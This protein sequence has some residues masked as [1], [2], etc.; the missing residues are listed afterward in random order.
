MS[1]PIVISKYFS[2]S[3]LPKIIPTVKKQQ[4]QDE[5]PT[6]ELSQHTDTDLNEQL[7]EWNVNTQEESSQKEEAS[8][9]SFLSTLSKK[10]ID[11]DAKDVEETEKNLGWYTESKTELDNDNELDQ[12]NISEDEEEMMDQVERKEEDEEEEEEECINNQRSILDINQ[13]NAS[14]TKKPLHSI[15][16]NQFKAPIEATENK[17]DLTRFNAPTTESP[18]QKFDLSLFKAPTGPVDLSQ[19]KMPLDPRY[20]SRIPPKKPKARKQVPDFKYLQGN[21]S[22]VIRIYPPPKLTQ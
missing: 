12:R 9:E 17:P 20:K 19:F 16:L 2:S 22:K 21:N 6:S 4:E 1:K 11:L 8:G 10:E 5:E 13:F 14:S 15:D 3:S 18:K 7:S